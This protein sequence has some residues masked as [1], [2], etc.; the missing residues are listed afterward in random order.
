MP[1]RYSNAQLVVFVQKAAD[2]VS[3]DLCLTGANCITVDASGCVTNPVNDKEIN[4]LV[5]M[6][7][8]C[9]ISQSDFNRDLEE[10]SIGILIRDGEQLVNNRDKAGA[11]AA[12]FDSSHGSCAQYD[13]RIQQIKL[14][15]NLSGKLVW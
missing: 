4:M 13:K 6:Q 11:R 12:L 3:S 5:L 8:E 14:N 15:R 1:T 2:I 10:D 7:A 9:L